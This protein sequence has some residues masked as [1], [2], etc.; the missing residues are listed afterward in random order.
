MMATLEVDM[1]DIARRIGIT[2]NLRGLTQWKLRVWIGT[3]LIRLAAWVM[4]VNIEFED[5]EE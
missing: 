4:W 5:G 2:V 1:E 3:Q